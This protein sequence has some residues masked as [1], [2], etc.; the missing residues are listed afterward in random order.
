MKSTQNPAFYEQLEF[1]QLLPEDLQLAPNILIQVWDNKTFGRVPVSAL[2][3]P[4]ADLS[5]FKNANTAEIPPP[6]W[7]ELF[8]IDGNRKLGEILVSFQLF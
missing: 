1:H 7:K 2:R 4:L 5:L 6:T 8:G 3:I